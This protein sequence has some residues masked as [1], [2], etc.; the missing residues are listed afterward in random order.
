[1]T[2]QMTPSHLLASPPKKTGDSCAGP[3]VT[4]AHTQA[5]NY[6]MPHPLPC[7]RSLWRKAESWVH[8]LELQRLYH[9]ELILTRTLEGQQF[10]CRES[11]LRAQTFCVST[12]QESS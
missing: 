8:Y 1:M 2:L 12:K 3:H 4:P 6:F 9:H 11:S 10:H 5:A 7:H